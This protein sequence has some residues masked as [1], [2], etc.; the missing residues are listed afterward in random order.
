MNKHL[1]L[2]AAAAAA[3]TSHSA[4]AALGSG[5]L[6]FTAFNADEDGFAMVALADIAAN[7]KV[8]FTDNEW[9][10]SAFNTGESYSSWLSGAS[11]ISAGT[12]IRFSKVDSATLRAASIGTFSRETV[13][14]SANW[15]ISASED[16]LYAYLGNSAT[17]PTTF[18]SAIT[19]GTY[20]SASAGSLAN[21]GL[22]VGNGAV[23]LSTGSDY[24]DYSGARTGQ[25]SFAGYKSLVGDAAQWTDLGTA[26]DGT[27][28]SPNTTAFAVSAV[29]EPES[30]ALMLG[31]LLAVGF[32]ARRRR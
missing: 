28:L 14:N 2:I 32:V 3:L 22:S 25:A 21:T 13:A 27:N 17:A 12:V 6:S 7:T 8:W 29:P 9:N 11:V 18:L 31:G 30:Y 16:T 15:G 5:D 20:G 19:T 26:A 4:L 23:K 24:A 10:G 1:A